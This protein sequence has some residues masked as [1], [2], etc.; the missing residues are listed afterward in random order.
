MKCNITA[1]N[2]SK[3][4]YIAAVLAIDDVFTEIEFDILDTLPVK[5]RQTLALPP[6]NPFYKQRRLTKNLCL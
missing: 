3:V 6:S 1:A 2:T 4:V 5:C